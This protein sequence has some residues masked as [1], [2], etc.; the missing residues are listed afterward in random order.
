MSEVLQDFSVISINVNGL[1]DVRKRRL[2][3]NSLKRFKR[4]IFLLQET[5][6][7]IGNG[8]LW[9]SQWSN[10]MFLTE[11]S[12]S[13]GGVA[14]LF[15]KDLTPLITKVLPSHSNRFL[16]TEM[17]LEGEKYS[18]VNLY[19]PTSDKEG[20]QMEVL[21]ELSSSLNSHGEEI[22]I[23][24]G[25]FNVSLHEDLDRS[26]Y[27]HP[28][29][30][31]TR[32]RTSLNNFLE[33]FDLI[34]LWRTQ[35]PKARDFTW[36]RGG[37]FARL[38]YI[39]CAESFP[40]K[41]RAAQPK[42]YSFSD[43]R[44]IAVTF[45]PCL[46]PKGKG[47]WR[48]RTSLLEREDFCEE[49]IQAITKGVND[50]SDLQPNTRWEYIKFTIREAAIAFSKRLKENMQRL[51]TELQSTMMDL[52]KEIL[53]DSAKAELYQ[54]LKRE[55]YQLQMT[56]ARE[57]MIRAKVK[58]VCEGE[59]PT[60]YFLNLEKKHFGSKSIAELFNNE[61]ILLT[62]PEDILAFER[63]FF[64]SQYG[65]DNDETPSEDENE[66]LQEFDFLAP[67]ERSISDLDRGV[68]NEGISLEE[69][70]A[71]VKGMKNGK[72]PGCDGLPV[73][74]YKR[75]WGLLGK[76]L[77]ASF[78]HAFS[79]GSLSPDQRRGIISLIPKKGRDKRY[80][81][82]WRPISMLNVDY[83]IL[84]KSLATR[85]SNIV[86]QLVHPN[87]TG[88]IPSRHIGDTIRNIQSLIEF[89]QNTGRSGLI[90]S[91]DFSAAFDSLR[92][93]YMIRALESFNLGPSFLK[94]I[95]ILY[96]SSETC[97]LN[98]GQ[99]SGW[100]PFK[101]GIRQGCPISPFLFVLAVEG[102]AE[103]I[104][105]RQDIRGLR[106]LD[107]ETK[108]LQF[109]DDST[110]FAEDEPSLLN[111]LH[112][113]ESF[114]GLS[115]LGLNLQKSQGLNIGDLPLI[116][117]TSKSLPWDNQAKIL[118]IKFQLELAEGDEWNLNFAPAI[119]KMERVCNSWRFRNVSLKGRAVI[120]NT[121]V[122]PIV[123]YPCVMLP[124]PPIAFKEI[125]RII[126]S[127]LWRGKKAKISRKCLEEP[128]HKG[129]LGLHNIHSR[130]KASKMSWLK[131]LTLPPK[132]PWQFHFEFMSDY[133]G[134]EVAAQRSKPTRLL[135]GS[136][137]FWEI[138]QHW[139][140][141][142]KAEPASDRA[143][144]NELLW[145]NPFLKGK[146]KKKQE[147][148][149]KALGISK[150]NDILEFGRILSGD[151]FQARFDSPPPQGFLEKCREIIPDAWLR[152]LSSTDQD[153]PEAC[154]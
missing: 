70:E 139:R 73:E 29:I 18:L 65:Q 140:E 107:S 101:R 21:H 69:M 13:V 64:A 25:D 124:V 93:D 55:L 131:K 39:F 89:T 144:R 44:M 45:R 87:Q 14:T 32:F 120:L 42:S 49:I 40:G 110:I 96:N 85:L 115:G 75:F 149:C 153:T 52:E 88:F 135:R 100:F 150:I 104:R 20:A 7:K 11:T 84:A 154:S 151:Q 17:E 24:G 35:S 67:S 98:R 76:H 90:V 19:M 6:C 63:S 109:A 61:G 4:S 47:F 116:H 125:D 86:P 22:L 72:C 50:S 31:N 37:K 108:I 74:L 23:I 48:M 99:S 121:L 111:T 78:Q 122:L 119:R 138:F 94:W 43:H 129:G 105:S 141:I 123:Y 26:G 127:F 118:G 102:L 54:T 91:L 103:V 57:S 80:I 137:F 92:H 106:L 28:F 62:R 38:D 97:V 5:H 30:P 8:R 34:D 152:L 60:K 132:E 33:R 36:S 112:T 147:R 126:S 58:W 27:A 148:N 16:I 9:K 3:F 12:G 41:M 51:E 128:T 83:K 117:P 53:R 146:F 46:H 77:L 15:S 10:T 71:A 142:S 81:R 2:V 133:S 130:V 134:I 113:I 66:T 56:G 1:N 79:S 136:P 143:K 95:K 59:R 145:G 114:K 82:N 68:L